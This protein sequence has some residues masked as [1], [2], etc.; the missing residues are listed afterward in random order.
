MDDQERRWL[1]LA[2]SIVLVWAVSQVMS[3]LFDS[4]E[5]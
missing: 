3:Q 1:A 4:P 5:E 2:L